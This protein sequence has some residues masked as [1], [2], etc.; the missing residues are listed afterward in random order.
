M[1]VFESLSSLKCIFGSRRSKKFAGRFLLGIVAFYELGYSLLHLS[2]DSVKVFWC[3]FGYA[4][5]IRNNIYENL[6]VL[7]R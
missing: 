5:H 3:G 2:N 4:L 1:G 6:R 7:K